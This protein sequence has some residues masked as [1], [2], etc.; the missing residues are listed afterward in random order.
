MGS[1]EIGRKLYEIDER[2]KFLIQDFAL[3]TAV[4]IAVLYTSGIREL[5]A[6]DLNH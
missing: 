1:D 3:C 4:A 6:G 2:S 5:S